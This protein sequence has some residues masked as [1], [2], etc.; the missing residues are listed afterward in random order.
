MR[1]QYDNELEA[2][3][4]DTIQS[5]RELNTDGQL[6]RVLVDYGIVPGL[7]WAGERGIEG[8]EDLERLRNNK[9]EGQVC[10]VDTTT[11][12]SAARL[13]LTPSKPSALS[14]IDLS[15]ITDAICLYDRVAYLGPVEVEHIGELGGAMNQ[16]LGEDIFFSV[17]P[18]DSNNYGLHLV[19]SDAVESFE[20]ILTSSLSRTQADTVKAGSARWSHFFGEPFDLVDSYDPGVAG[21][22][23]RS[24]GSGYGRWLLQHFAADAGTSLLHHPADLL[25]KFGLSRAEFVTETHIRAM[26]NAHLAHF[27]L[28]V[29]YRASVLRSPWTADVANRASILDG[30]FRVGSDRAQHSDLIVETL[31]RVVQA[32]R[33]AYQ[34]P[35]IGQLR[36]RPML[37][38]ALERATSL[39]GLAS[40]IGALRAE[41]RKFRAKQTEFLAALGGGAQAKPDLRLAQRVANA[42]AA[43][44]PSTMAS[45]GD[46]AVLTLKVVPQIALAPTALSGINATNTLIAAARDDG[47]LA[48]LCRRLFRPGLHWLTATANEAGAIINSQQSTMRIWELDQTEADLLWGSLASLT[49]ELSP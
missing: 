16:M 39:P 2:T 48:R 19:F 6:G 49:V 10:L 46:A 1:V 7:G 20:T 31:N 8:L 17:T 38:I 41:A 3:A 23:W 30:F 37:S 14:F 13:L 9:P 42:L 4:A 28:E 24:A 45:A 22:A 12:M 18:L 34:S 32:R 11:L 44:L 29:P 27:V 43:D 40:E 5:D 25:N 33:T 21:G 26:F 47:L 36:I 15:V 35:T